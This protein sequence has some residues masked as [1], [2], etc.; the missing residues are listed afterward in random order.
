MR[1]LRNWKRGSAD[2]IGSFWQACLLQEGEGPT[3]PYPDPVTG[4]HSGCP[5]RQSTYGEG[6]DVE[7]GEIITH[8]YTSQ[9]PAKDPGNGAQ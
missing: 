3:R 6:V 5:A 1:S 9:Q 8:M 4:T 2:V 7:T